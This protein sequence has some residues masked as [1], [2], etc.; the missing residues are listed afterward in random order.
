MKRVTVRKKLILLTLLLTVSVSLLA[1][2]EVEKKVSSPLLF[3]EIGKPGGEFVLS[4]ATA[5]ETFNYYAGIDASTFTVM[6]NVLDSLLEA[7]PVTQELEPGL[8]KS[9]EV[10]KDGKKVTLYLRRGVKWSDG[11]QFTA[12]DVIFTINNL[13]AN[14]YCESNEINRLKIGEELVKFTKVDNYTVTI[15]MPAAYGPF[16]AILSQLPMAPKH[17]LEKFVSKSDPG[18]INKAWSTGENLTNIVGTGPFKLAEYKVGQKLVLKRNPY[19]WRYDAKG[20]QLPYVDKLIYLIV[21]NEEVNLAKFEAGELDAIEVKSNQYSY[22]KGKEKSG[23]KFTIFKCQPTKPTPSPT[24][25]S[26]NFDIADPELRAAFR[27]VRFREAMDHLIER[28]RIIE[29]VYNTLA[30]VSGVPVLPSNYFYNANIDK[31]RRAFNLKKAQAILDELGYRDIDNDGIREL[32]S[33]KDFQFT[34]TVGVDNQDHVDI[35]SLLKDNMEAVG[36]KINLNPIKFSLVFDKALAGDFESTIMAFGNQPDPQFRKAIWQPG[37]PLYYFHLSA[38][39]KDTQTPIVE[40][41]FDW[42]KIVFNNFEQGQILMDPL[43]RKTCYDQWQEIY[44]KYLPV[45]FI[46]KGMELKGAKNNVGNYFINEHGV[47]VNTN[48]S[49]F[50]K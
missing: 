19:S 47:L 7:N 29:E 10:S 5:P 46:T 26:F 36:L 43:E 41:M 9:W 13:A 24:H 45:I 15:E 23:A 35:A 49:V 2:A 20:N 44:I 11:V 1:A 6:T 50:K 34:L 30:I 17:K 31:Y 14:P 3:K 21:A 18:A 25:I 40:N 28:E 22:L 39:K 32:P 27:N 42:E 38:M 16:L 37:R 8:A 48:Y 33:G 12:D 4:L